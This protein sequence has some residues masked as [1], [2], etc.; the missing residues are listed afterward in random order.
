MRELARGLDNLYH[1]RPRSCGAHLQRGALVDARSTQ[2]NAK[3][4]SESRQQLGLF[5]AEL[6]VGEDAALV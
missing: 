2:E 3:L 4:E 5:A 6:V 1:S